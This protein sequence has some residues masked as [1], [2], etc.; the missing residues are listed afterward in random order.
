MEK[1]EPVQILRQKYERLLELKEDNL[2]E[3]KDNTDKYLEHLKQQDDFE[4]SFQ[5]LGYDIEKVTKIRYTSKRN[6]YKVRLKK[7]DN[8]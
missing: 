2:N 7:N 4:K 8:K 5:A 6:R 3:L 1:S